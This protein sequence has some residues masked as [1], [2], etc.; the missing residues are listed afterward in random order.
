MGPNG[1]SRYTSNTAALFSDVFYSA[2]TGTFSPSGHRPRTQERYQGSF[3]LTRYQPRSDSSRIPTGREVL[4]WKLVVPGFQNSATDSRTAK[5]FAF[6]ERGWIQGGCG[7][8]PL[9]LGTYGLRR[10]FLPPSVHALPQCCYPFAIS[11][12][13]D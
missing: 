2:S 3:L 12:M 8:W 6:Y 13:L 7:Y 5:N 9:H 11:A 1:Q 4:K 10:A